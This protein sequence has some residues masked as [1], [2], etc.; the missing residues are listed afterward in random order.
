MPWCS[1]GDAVRQG[2]PD[3]ARAAA[4]TV[5]LRLFFWANALWSVGEQR[6]LKP[7]W[8]GRKTE[9][10]RLLQASTSGLPSTR[11]RSHEQHRLHRGLYRHRPRPPVVFRTALNR[12][13][14]FERRPRADGRAC[15][16]VEEADAAERV[17][18]DSRGACRADTRDFQFNINIRSKRSFRAD[19]GRGVTIVH[20]AIQGCVCEINAL[21]AARC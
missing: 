18:A 4:Q 12:P 8:K 7:N 20:A 9:V 3:A 5:R 13:R 1:S 19:I 2:C 10:Q 6:T 14:F 15:M 11:R 21:R 16:E 17:Q